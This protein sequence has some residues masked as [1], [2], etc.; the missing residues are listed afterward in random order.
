MANQAMA[1]AVEGYRTPSRMRKLQTVDALE[2]MLTVIKAAAGDEQTLLEQ[3][4]HYQADQVMVQEAA[5]FFLLRYLMAPGVKGIQLLG[6]KETASAVE[7]K[8]HKRWLMKWLHPDRNPSPWEQKLFHRI[9]E[10]KN[11]GPDQALPKT[12]VQTHNAGSRKVRSNWSIARERKKDK[13]PR[14]A[15][16]LALR[17]LVFG[18]ALALFVL[19]LMLLPNTFWIKLLSLFPIGST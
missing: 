3:G 19:W 14:R 4:A 9:S 10:L 5:K 2:G 13:S 1:L 7:I 18:A 16:F 17:P 11:E 15:L 6:L 8:D 12:I